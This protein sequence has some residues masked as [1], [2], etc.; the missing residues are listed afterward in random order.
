MS[1]K[2][3]IA[4]S[5]ALIASLTLGCFYGVPFLKNK[6]SIAEAASTEYFVGDDGKIAVPMRDSSKSVGDEKNPF[7]VLEIV[8]YFKEAFF[9]YQID[10][11]APIDLDK[12]GFFMETGQSLPDNKEFMIPKN[13][14]A[15]GYFE[16]EEAYK[17]LTNGVPE[18][19]LTSGNFLK[20]LP[21]IGTVTKTP[22]SGHYK[23]E[24]TGDAARLVF[25]EAGGQ[26]YTFTPEKVS[27]VMT[28]QHDSNKMNEYSTSAKYEDSYKYNM[29]E[30]KAIYR[31]NT[32]TY[33]HKDMFLKYSVGLAYK[34]NSSGI[35]TNPNGVIA[36]ADLESVKSKIDSYNSI[37]YTVTPQELDNNLALVD[38]ADMIVI[39][40][41]CNAQNTD[42]PDWLYTQQYSP[43]Y[44][45]SLGARNKNVDNATFKD[46]SNTISW[47]AV[48]AIYNR[49]SDFTNKCPIILDN[50]TYQDAFAG[51]TGSF[52][53]EVT[54]ADNQK[55]TLSCSKASSNNMYKLVLLLTEMKG[56]VFKQ[57][58]GTTTGNVLDGTNFDDTGKFKG[59][60]TWSPELF[61][62]YEMINKSDCMNGSTF[63][64]NNL[65]NICD[66][67][68]IMHTMNSGNFLSGNLQDFV[69][70]NGYKYDGGVQMREK[71][72]FEANATNT[73]ITRK[74][75]LGAEVFEFWDKAIGGT[76]AG[77]DVSNILYYILHYDSEMNPNRPIVGDIRVLDIE[78]TG[79]FQSKVALQDKIELMLALSSNFSGK[80][81]VDQMSSSEFIGKRIEIVSDYDFVFMGTTGT[82]IDNY[83]MPNATAGTIDPNYKPEIKKVYT[84]ESGLDGF[85]AH[86]NDAVK[87][88]LS[89]THKS[90][91]KSM[92]VSNRAETWQGAGVKINDAGIA[93]RTL[94]VE[95]S[96][97]NGNWT[98]LMNVK[99]TVMFTSPSTGAGTQYRQ[100]ATTSKFTGENGGRGWETVRGEVA[101]PNDATNV[102]VFFETDDTNGNFFIDDLTITFPA[103]GTAPSALDLGK[104][105]YAHTGAKVTIKPTQNGSCYG[106][107]GYLT[108]NFDLADSNANSDF[109]KKEQEFIYSGNDLTKDSYDKIVDFAERYKTDG[110]VPIIFDAGFFAS[111][112]MKSN[113]AVSSGI[114]RNS[115]IFKLIPSDRSKALYVSAVLKPLVNAGDKDAWKQQRTNLETITRKV[116]STRVKLLKLTDNDTYVGP[117]SLPR[118]GAT[119]TS[120]M[121]TNENFSIR[122]KVEDNT[123]STYQLHFYIDNDFDGVLSEEELIDDYEVAVVNSNG[124]IDRP[125]RKGNITGNK[126]Y[127]FQRK[128]TG[129]F[130]AISWKL[131]LVKN[132]QVVSSIDG[133]YV[134]KL[135]AGKANEALTILQI[136]PTQDES[137]D[138]VTILLPTED[139]V[140]RYFNGDTTELRK[141]TQKFIDGVYEKSGSSYKSRINGL[142]LKFSRMTAEQIL[143]AAGA[144]NA[145]ES[146]NTRVE[147]VYS[148]FVTNYK[149]LV[150]GFA[151][152]YKV[153][154]ELKQT[155]DKVNWSK[156]LSDAI[157]KFSNDGNS[158]LYTHDATSFVGGTKDNS[159]DPTKRW[160][161]QVTLATRASFGMDRYNV[162]ENAGSLTATRDDY[163]YTPL[164]TGNAAN[165][166]SVM[167]NSVDSNLM[168]AQGYTN[169][170]LFRILEYNNNP[171]SNYVDIVNR[172]PITNYP[173]NIPDVISTSTTHTQYYQL[174]FDRT[175]GA[176]I[177]V[178]CTLAGT[179]NPT[180]NTAP[181]GALEEYYALTR[182]DTRNNYYIYNIGNITYTGVGHTMDSTTSAGL[183]DDEVMLFI[184]TFVAAYRPASEPAG[185]L[186][187]NDDAVRN[188][189]DYYLSVD[190]D[191][192][193][194]AGVIENAD[195]VSKYH[196][197]TVGESITE[198]GKEVG[199]KYTT[200]TENT[201]TSKLVKFEILD[202]STINSANS[203]YWVTAKTKV[204]GTDVT[205]AIYEMEGSTPKFISNST[206]LDRAKEYY[207]EVPL[208]TEGSS[209]AITITEVTFTVN[210]RYK[211][212]NK[213]KESVSNEV[214]VTIAPRGLFDLD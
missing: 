185:I 157:V 202:N 137:W 94:H 134:L 37:V 108:R 189:K 6:S 195:I 59:Q 54:F 182:K 40:T 122:I 9:G 126:E 52:N 21:C 5:I 142:D 38:R 79:I 107:Y 25:V 193:N 66:L 63:E 145:S 89:N 155:G 208:K 151:D 36:D 74:D 164:A 102:E 98:T 170:I 139:E 19:Y 138:A 1:K 188:D 117:S 67:N 144:M 31:D 42:Y 53:Y 23:I 159:K 56:P 187:T 120:G 55:Q 103:V 95:F 211:V 34:K 175:D 13:N 172:G 152:G 11:C 125:V 81:T 198:D 50:Q 186:V 210:S 77:V 68:E 87:V 3:K 100:V 150:M 82:T 143:T 199:C 48:K 204:N 105:I 16:I 194:V 119:V 190:V 203:Y 206:S 96:A 168:L 86:G 15:L 212:S 45:A 173:Y 14:G 132:N 10:G 17:K 2:W 201:K 93:G 101:L 57:L 128:I 197:T 148:Y 33:E 116:I 160:A 64:R 104:F 80:V 177:N 127:V 71:F 214:K 180:S 174:A 111:D 163:P 41:V 62:P 46:G 91:S 115:N 147:K 113:T 184:N 78:P 130:G 191:S 149:M 73:V 123:S 179:K 178:W 75:G 209:E 146:I 124:S 26:D 133:F 88:E 84:F 44:L 114:D 106:L 166:S 162:V 29:G 43:T 35:I 30:K 20:N 92:Y 99:C 85:A 161:R 60:M 118:G 169:G 121:S 70:G 69:I 176:K 22:G 141:A 72:Y 58:F 207:V 165:T 49:V 90:G 65:E 76:M 183:T 135:Q 112:V 83:M 158:V 24:G 205:L 7:F 18:S 213:L 156:I 196:T 61:Y 192:D 110:I 181:S 200:P 4:V 131:D 12:Y 109:T 153:A 8:P 47:A 39:S 28:W 167:K 154:V 171:L 140:R 51:A 97:T 136:E 32:Y 129:R 27:D